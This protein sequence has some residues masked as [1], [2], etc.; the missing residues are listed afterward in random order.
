MAGRTAL[1]LG[2]TGGV[3]GAAAAALLRRGWNVVA[4]ARDARKL[5]AGDPLSKARWVTGD[6]M[7]AADVLSAAAGVQAIVHAVNPAR[8]HDWGGLIL[9]MI[10]NTIAAAKATGARV[11]LPGT[12][13]N[14]GYDAFP[15]LKEDAPQHPVSEKGACAS[16]SNGGWSRRAARG[17]RR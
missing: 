6:A 1:V 17:R 3:G 10:D 12:I 2:A 4:M 5:A 14:Y 9:P 11:V 8:Y 16:S 7:R 13:Y 15:E